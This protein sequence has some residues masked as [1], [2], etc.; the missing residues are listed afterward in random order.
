MDQKLDYRRMLEEGYA[1]IRSFSSG[2]SESRLKYLSEYI[3]DFTTYD[4]EMAE[5]FARKALEVCAAISESKTF[6]YIKDAEQYRWYLVMCN[7]PFFADK[8]EWGT[9]IRGA[10]WG[11]P[12]HK[13]IVLNSCGLWMDNEQLHETMEFTRDQ[14]HEFIASVLAFGA[15]EPNASLSGEE[16]QAT[17]PTRSES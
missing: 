17:S 5:L 8:L 14:W 9:S 3:F 7:M 1:E 13:K 10:W 12:P 6:D 2:A 15:D 16:P 4:D 11:E